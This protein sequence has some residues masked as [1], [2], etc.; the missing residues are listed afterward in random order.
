MPEIK[1]SQG[2]VSIVDDCDIDLASRYRWRVQNTAS[3]P[4]ARAWSPM[5]NKKRRLLLLHREIAARLFGAD[6]SKNMKIDHV[7]GDG[8]DNRRCN[9]RL[10]TASQNAMNKRRGRVHS[11][12]FKGVSYRAKTGRWRAGICINGST[13]DIGTFAS[14]V[15]AAQAYNSAAM[16]HYGEFARL[17]SFEDAS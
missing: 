16:I 5:V 2:Q 8:L 14:E 7:N 17:N 1:L 13:K 11:S 6:Q 12:R 9:L 15:K 4:Y 3:G 10:C